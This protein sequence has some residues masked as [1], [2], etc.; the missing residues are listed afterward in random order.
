MLPCI[1][2]GWTSPCVF[3][4][5]E[6]RFSQPWGCFC[7][8]TLRLLALSVKQLRCSLCDVVPFAS[9]S[10]GEDPS[11]VRTPDFYV[12]LCTARCCGNISTITCVLLWGFSKP[13]RH[14]RRSMVALVGNSDPFQFCG[15]GRCVVTANVILLDLSRISLMHACLQA[16]G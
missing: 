10:E 12:P 2:A 4:S 9:I 16:G 1:A 6:W 7:V 11:F 15:I 13:C 14:K 3:S 8:H 5:R